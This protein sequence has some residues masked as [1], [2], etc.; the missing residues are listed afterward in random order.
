M[1]ILKNY[2]MWIYPALYDI[3]FKYRRSIIGPWWVTISTFIMIALLTIVWSKVFNINPKEYMPY[4]AF[5]LIF[6]NWFSTLITESSQGFG[7]Y[8]SIIKQIK[9]D[10]L[11]LILRL[12]IKNLIIFLHNSILIFLILIYVDSF[13]WNLIFFIPVIFYLAINFLFLS[14]ITFYLSTRF[15]DMSQIIVN[16]LQAAFFFTPIIWDKNII[17][18]RVAF[19][20]LNPI[21]HYLELFRFSVSENYL[22]MPSSFYYLTLQP[23]IFFLLYLLVKKY[24]K[25][26]LLLWI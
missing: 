2:Q 22:I 6:W 18:E 19:L 25:R 20:E 26:R 1:K 17:Q 13:N 9:I 7:Q 10:P 11:V 16:L 21:Y 24:S 15:K 4:F 12:N 14:S 5:G 23:L 3:K 8:E